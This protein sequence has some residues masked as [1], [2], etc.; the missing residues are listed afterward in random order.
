[1]ARWMVA[2]TLRALNRPEEA[3][4]LQLQLELEAQAAGQPDHHIFD[5][6]ETLYRDAG[7]QERSALY[8]ARKAAVR[9]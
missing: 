6:L 8:A 7:D 2:W 3:L 4:A 9:P 5:E 1:M